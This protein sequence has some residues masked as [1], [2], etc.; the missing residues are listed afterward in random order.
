MSFEFLNWKRDKKAVLIFAGFY[1]SFGMLAAIFQERLI[2]IPNGQDFESC[3]DFLSA[4]KVNYKGTRMYFR[5]NGSRLAVFYHGNAGSACDR[6][7]IAEIFSQ[8]GY[9]YLIPE[10][11][12]YSGGSVQ[13]THELLLGDVR[14]TVQFLKERNFSE[15]IVVGESIGT[16]FA[17][18]HVSLA[19]PRALV[20][21]SP[22]PTLLDIAKRKFWFYPV[23]LMVKTPFNSKEL[24]RNFKGALLVIHGDQDSIVPLSLGK[25]LFSSIVTKEKN[26]L[27]VEGAGHNDLFSFP[28]TYDALI[29]FLK[30]T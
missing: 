21:I 19:S 24:L 4:E 25:E 7:F 22:F 30:S 15:I 13:P 3:P 11:A 23:S 10:Y 26:M 14:H 6:A 5:N 17:S 16:G 12:G 28:E 18:Y 9:S 29:N 8:N 27:V 1:V 2:Y 20:L